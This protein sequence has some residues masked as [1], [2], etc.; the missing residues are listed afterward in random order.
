MTVH[1]VGV[2][3]DCVD[4]ELIK[5]FWSQALDLPDVEQEG[6][7]LLL[8]AEAGA[9]RSG[10]RGLTLQ[11]VPEAKS[12]KN[13]M[14][15]DVVVD[16]VDAEVDRLVALGATVLAREAEP[17]AEELTVMSDPEGNEFCVIKARPTTDQEPSTDA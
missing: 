7:Y 6:D 11:R 13:R 2:T 3:L 5:G 16:D 12:G 14:H 10:V 15:L 9:S 17:T 8:R 4:L 1:H